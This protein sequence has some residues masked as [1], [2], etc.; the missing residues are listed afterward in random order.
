[1]FFKKKKKQ[2]NLKEV[3]SC[4]K[5]TEEETKRLSLELE[6]VKKKNRSNLQKVGMIRFNPFSEAG[7]DQSFSIA[8]LDEKNNGV[9]LTSHYLRDLNRVYAKPIKEGKSHYSLS[10]EEKQAIKK[11]QE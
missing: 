9:V 6:E 5:R 4:L 1:M 2:Q 11:A 7:G 3:L 8:L 10:K